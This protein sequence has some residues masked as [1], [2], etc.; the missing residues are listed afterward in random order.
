MS[1][2]GGGRIGGA[3]IKI[4]GNGR[5]TQINP[6]DVCCS[7]H[8]E[9]CLATVQMWCVIPWAFAPKIPANRDAPL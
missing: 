2:E 1:R 6:T 5:G 9:L 8:A 7:F 4:G 3:Q